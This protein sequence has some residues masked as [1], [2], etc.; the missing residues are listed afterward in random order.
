M[1]RAPLRVGWIRKLSPLLAAPA[2]LSVTPSI[3]CGNAAN[4]VW[5]LSVKRV[6]VQLP[7]LKDRR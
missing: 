4:V 6:S 7:A 1:S 3:V 2:R 5:V